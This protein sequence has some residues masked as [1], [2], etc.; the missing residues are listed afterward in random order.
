MREETQEAK[1]TKHSLIVHIISVIVTVV[2]LTGGFLL[3]QESQLTSF[4]QFLLPAPI[5]LLSLRYSLWSGIGAISLTMFNVSL[6]S[7]YYSGVFFL[8]G[9]GVTAIV[10]TVGFRYNA[11]LLTIVTCMTLYYIILE[12]GLIYTQKD[13]TFET[14][15]Q[16][17][18]MM[19]KKMLVSFYES[20]DAGW[21]NFEIQFEA[22]ARALSVTSPLISALSMSTLMYVG[23]RSMLRVRK[24]VLAP[25]GRFQDWRISEYFVWGLVFA[26]ILYHIQ[27]TR[28]IGINILLGLVFLYYVA[29]CAIIIYVLKQKETSKFFQI[30]AYILLFFQIPHIFT[31]LGLLLI[32]YS[33]NGVYLSLPAI[34][35]V[36]GVGLSDIWIDFRQR[37]KQA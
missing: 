30:I 18:M 6:L 26:G 16:E 5:I 25:L 2:I 19:F 3:I 33:E 36:A 24:I 20:K 37:V 9:I 7:G 4:L 22:I 8:L 10:L 1:P 31:G 17:R 11:S 28:V 35:L 14:H 23:S 32:G 27:Y 34:I 29:G 15:I 21:Q 13:I 12:I